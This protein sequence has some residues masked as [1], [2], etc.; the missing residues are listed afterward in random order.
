MAIV[1][2]TALPIVSA[3]AGV[4]DRSIDKWRGGERMGITVDS[5]SAICTNRSL[6]RA[7]CGGQLRGP[8]EPAPRDFASGL[9]RPNELPS[10][11]PARI[12]R[13]VHIEVERRRVGDD[14]VERR[15]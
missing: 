3:S 13:R 14:G 7:D 4:Y 10:R 1:P 12:Q 5:R 2:Q 15:G 11:E 8:A 6:G 9:Q